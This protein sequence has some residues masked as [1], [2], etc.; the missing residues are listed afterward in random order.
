MGAN[1]AR[2]IFGIVGKDAYDVD[3]E[4]ARDDEE[5]PLGGSGG[6]GSDESGDL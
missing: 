5:E 2:E 1:L 3:E 6:E 4:E